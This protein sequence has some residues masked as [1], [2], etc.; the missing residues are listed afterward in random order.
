MMNAVFASMA[1]R[2]PTKLSVASVTLSGYGS[3]L[4]LRMAR[5]HPRARGRVLQVLPSSPAARAL[6]LPAPAPAPCALIFDAAATASLDL[7]DNDA[8]CRWLDDKTLVFLLGSRATL[9]AGGTVTMRGPSVGY[10]TH[11]TR[12]WAST[13]VVNVS[14]PLAVPTVTITAPA[15]LGACADLELSVRGSV[16]VA[17][18]ADGSMSVAWALVSAG[19]A[20]ASAG[21]TVNSSGLAAVLAA[22]VGAGDL[23]VPQASMPVVTNGGSAWTLGMNISA[24]GRTR[25]GAAATATVVVMVSSSTTAPTVTMSTA[26]GSD[27]TNVVVALESAPTCGSTGRRLAITSALSRRTVWTVAPA[28]IAGAGGPGID[29]ASSPV[30]SPSLHVPRTAALP[31]VVYTFTLRAGPVGAVVADLV[32][33]ATTARVVRAPPLAPRVANAGG[34]AAAGS[35]PI[36]LSVVLDGVIPDLWGP[37][38]NVSWRCLYYAPASTAGDPDAATGAA[39]LTH[40]YAGF[41]GIGATGGGGSAGGQRVAPGAG[42]TY[43]DVLGAARGPGAACSVQLAAYVVPCAASGPPAAVSCLS[44]PAGVLAAGDYVF[45]A[46]VTQIAH[47]WRGGAATYSGLAGVPAATAVASTALSVYSAAVPLVVARAA[48]AQDDHV[49]VNVGDR[50]VLRGGALLDELS[51]GGVRGAGGGGG[52]AAVPRLWASGVTVPAAGY[53]RIASLAALPTCR[54]G[55]PASAA[56]VWAVMDGVLA[57]ALPPGAYA[58]PVLVLPPGSLSGGERYVFRLVVGAVVGRN[59]SCGTGYAEVTVAVNAPP[60]P[61][62][63]AVVAVGSGATALAGVFGVSTTGW[64]DRDGDVPLSYA[65]LAVVT[66]GAEPVLVLPA[67][68]DA[69]VEV[70]LPVGTTAVIVAVSDAAGGVTMG[71]PVAVSVA[72]AGAATMTAEGLSG[73]WAPPTGLAG[74]LSLNY[75]AAAASVVAA[76]QRAAS[77]TAA[78]KDVAEAAR[79]ALLAAI[80]AIPAAS[81]GAPGVAAALSAAGMAGRLAALVRPSDADATAR[82]VRTSV[83]AALTA[84]RDV[85]AAVTGL[86]A[87]LPQPP[88]SNGTGC[89]PGATGSAWCA[90]AC[91]TGGGGAWGVFPRDLVASIAAAAAERGVC[92]A[93]RTPASNATAVECS[94]SSGGVVLTASA[95]PTASRALATATVV[96]SATPAAG[97]AECATVVL[98]VLPGARC[99]LHATVTSPDAVVVGSVDVLSVASFAPRAADDPLTAFV[100]PLAAGASGAPDV[101]VTAQFSLSAD[102]ATAVGSLT[103]AQR[104]GGGVACA[105]LVD[106]GAQWSPD[107]CTTSTLHLAAGAVSCTCAV[108]AGGALVHVAVLVST[109]CAADTL[110]PGAPPS[111]Y[112]RSDGTCAACAPACGGGYAEVTA[113]TA[114]ANRACVSAGAMCADGVAT[115]TTPA[116]AVWETGVDCGGA[117]AAACAAGEGCIVDTD[118]AAPATCGVTGVCVAPSGGGCGSCE[119]AACAQDADCGAD[120]SCADGVCVGDADQVHLSLSLAG[121]TA[122]GFSQGDRAACRRGV[123]DATRVPISRV[124]IVSVTDVGTLLLRGRALS[125]S[126]TVTVAIIVP[127]GS[128]A[129]AIAG[130][131]A[132]SAGDGTLAAAIVAR[133]VNLPPSSIG[134]VS[135]PRTVPGVAASALPGEPC[136]SSTRCTSGLCAGGFCCASAVA[137]ANCATCAASTGHCATCNNNYYLVATAGTCAAELP[138]PGVAPTPT[139]SL[140][141][142]IGLAAGAAGLLLCCGVVYSCYR[143]ASS[144]RKRVLGSKQMY[145]LKPPSAEA[146]AA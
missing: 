43:V 81:A 53:A 41:G 129:G 107:A 80:A 102:G 124:V 59:T 99:R 13:H 8:S 6:G 92:G 88:S 15:S 51:S 89:A 37:V 64:T 9:A 84:T 68:F 127:A 144:G 23:T 120:S 62:T 32:V 76:V 87:A 112:V 72:A 73:A 52:A 103:P 61:G 67:Q 1:P 122:A 143:C 85:A 47:A 17:T 27:D 14:Y 34:A 100:Q 66:G 109:A 111:V 110:A 145:N 135:A 60:T 90:L 132:V 55:P 97:A 7:A 105:L 115:T 18:R 48:G 70:R 119:G 16:G 44:L 108:P 31:G 114:R 104:G 94:Y 4:V 38:V 29:P 12:A 3:L 36:L 98:A 139:P 101:N 86:G 49:R 74:E 2:A 63:T 128:S 133:G 123:A 54:A 93:P 24:T 82:G 131:A 126:V 19:L 130:A 142:V 106:G 30:M 79:G 134:L 141:V 116:S 138:T 50:L 71:G 113:C 96:A 75:V 118:C 140:S 137:A 21:A 91:R 56:F 57:A 58:A 46:N 95:L 117:C 45:S 83:G 5:P 125:G 26:A 136:A 20:G 78:D 146:H 69:R 65:V 11:S 39:A 33:V 121:A 28:L 35:M 22:A 40:L 77:A 25:L 10:S 42:M